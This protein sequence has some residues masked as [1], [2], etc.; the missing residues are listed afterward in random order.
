MAAI[1]F[2]PV[3]LF[4]GISLNL[5]AQEQYIESYIQEGLQS[6]LALRKIQADYS[7]SLQS[8]RSAKGLFYPDVS[9]NARYTVSR[10]GRTIPVGDMINPVY[11][12]LNQLLQDDVFEPIDDNFYFYRPTEHETK[13]SLVQPVYNPRVIYNYQIR[14]E[15]TLIETANVNI[16]KRE[17]IKEIKSA[18]Y[19]YLMTEYLVKLVDE[20]E[21]LLQENLRVSKSLYENDKVTKDV[22]YRSEAELQNVYLGRA[23]AEKEN[24]AARSYFNFLLNKPLDSE[25]KYDKTDQI[26]ELAI[27][28]SVEQGITNGLNTREELDKLQ[29]YSVINEK[30]TKLARSSN[31]PNLFLALD[32]GYQGEEYSF[33]GEDDFLLASVVLRWD[34]FQGF[35]NRAEVQHARIAGEQIELQKQELTKQIELQVITAYYELK[36]AIKAIDAARTQVKASEN[37]FQVTEEKYRIGQAKLIEYTD[38]RTTMTRSKQNLIIAVF[39]YKIKEAEFERVVGDRIIN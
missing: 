12:T 7:K 22:V 21:T 35:K 13:L 11:L 19:A 14:K 29:S 5:N 28:L 38:A 30:Y 1:K 37:A 32:Y 8:L 18:Y 25:I 33:T 26:P 36:A 17:L 6:N 10:G 16:Y 31:Y 27:P 24:M 15:Q 3:Y 9:L 20:T 4:L 23:E 2:I 39:E 34:L